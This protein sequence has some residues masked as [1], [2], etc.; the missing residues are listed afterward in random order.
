MGAQEGG[1]PGEVGSW[2]GAEGSQRRCEC[3]G[4]GPSP[5]SSRLPA[6]GVQHLGLD[7]DKHELLVS[8]CLYVWLFP[9][10]QLVF[11]RH[12]LWP[13]LTETLRPPESTSLDHRATRRPLTCPGVR[14]ENCG[15]GP[16]THPRLPGRRQPKGTPWGLKYAPANFFS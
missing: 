6:L 5:A 13:R 3:C 2:R 4:T 8:I 14:G 1:I 10:Q 9:C 12:R 7:P 15:S 11:P 16:Q